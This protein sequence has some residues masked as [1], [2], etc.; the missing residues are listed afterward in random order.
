MLYRPSLNVYEA[1]KNIEKGEELLIDYCVGE[2]DPEVR[3]QRLWD[4]WGIR[5]HFLD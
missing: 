3:E 2:M 5:E 4:S 1:S